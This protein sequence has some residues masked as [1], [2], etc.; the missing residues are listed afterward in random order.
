MSEIVARLGTTKRACRYS[1]EEMRRCDA[2]PN[3]RNAANPIPGVHRLR[4]SG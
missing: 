3:G 2:A 1:S 4:H